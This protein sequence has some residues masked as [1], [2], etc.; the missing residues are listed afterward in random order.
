[1]GAPVLP[2]VLFPSWGLTELKNSTEKAKETIKKELKSRPL[3]SMIDEIIAER[4]KPEPS[5][6]G[7]G[8][9]FEIPD[10]MVMFYKYSYGG[11][12]K[13]FHELKENA[14][15]YGAKCKS[16]GMVYFPPR[17]H[18]S[19]CYSETS[20]QRV[21]NEGIVLSSTTSWYATS[22]FF[23]VV[24]YAVGYVKPLDADTGI[25]QRIDL[26]GKEV[27]EPGTKVTA[28]FREKRIGVVSDFWYEMMEQD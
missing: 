16:C 25:L 12:S 27:I 28:R 26:R 3:E 4:L 18:C 6:L 19:E 14:V 5:V 21:S 7:R 17:T 22:D 15:L 9:Y 8:D 2:T 20:W 11:Q 23:D 1:M 24:P 10:K 13:F